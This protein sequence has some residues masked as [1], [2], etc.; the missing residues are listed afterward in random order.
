M[1]N[2]DDLQNK[3][4]T[5]KAMPENSVKTPNSI[6]V[7]AYLQEAENL[8]HRAC[9]DKEKLVN[10]GLDW[11]I[12][13]DLP[14]RTG[15]L[16]EA[17]SKWAVSRF[18]HEEAEK[19]WVEKSPEAY[20]L[21]DDLLATFRFA[22][23]NSGDISGRVSAIA[24]G[25]SN[26]DMLQDLNDLS[27]LGKEHPEELNMIMFDMS[28]LDKA[29]ETSDYLAN[30]LGAA[31]SDRDDTSEILDT[32]NRAYTHCKQAVDYICD[33]GRFIFR[34]DEKKVKGYSSAYLRRARQKY[35]R[36]N[37]ETASPAAE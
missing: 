20:D 37:A 22:Y 8:Y 21:R 26:A 5:L 17:E 18:T 3:M 35:A 28:L 32:R 33:Y 24:E 30:L 4:D 34:H 16:R 6:P 27:V 19:E 7:D 9:E 12:A 31:T 2:V 29:A 11:S 23:R 25:E 14:V 1:S 10:T 36:K 13:D 15:A